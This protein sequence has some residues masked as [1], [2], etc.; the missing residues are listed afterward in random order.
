MQKPGQEAAGAGGDKADGAANSGFKDRVKNAS[1]DNVYTFTK[2]FQILMGVIIILQATI[3]LFGTDN[4][5][6]FTGFLLTFYLYIIAIGIFAIECN[7]KRAR[8]WFYFMNF[9]LG[10]AM[11]YLVMALLC[12]SSGADISFFDILVGVVC[13]LACAM[14]VVFHMW[15]KLEEPAYVQK[16]IE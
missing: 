5:R 3:R 11:F 7:C 15:F 6:V 12:F 1:I 14:F 2:C 9:S 16:L 10:K 4:F 13:G 8:V